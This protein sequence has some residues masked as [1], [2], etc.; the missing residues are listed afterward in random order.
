MAFPKP[1]PRTYKYHREGD[2]EFVVEDKKWQHL[3]SVRRQWEETTALWADYSLK[4]LLP[5]EQKI[6]I[7]A[8]VMPLADTHFKITLRD[9]SSGWHDSHTRWN[10]FGGRL[11]S[12]GNH[13]AKKDWNNEREQT[14]QP[15]GF[16][17]DW[18]SDEWKLKRNRYAFMTMTGMKYKNGEGLYRFKL[19]YFAKNNRKGQVD[20]MGWIYS[21]PDDLTDF[22]LLFTTPT[23]QRVDVEA[24]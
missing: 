21:E 1:I 10:S 7:R 3:Y 5:I 23:L 6:I 2:R 18:G 19:D 15:D 8:V 24:W 14:P 20:I 17:L 11:I 16:M 22:K 13:W 12:G 4:G 9:Y